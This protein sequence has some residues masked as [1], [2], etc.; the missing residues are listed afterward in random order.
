[1]DRSTRPPPART[2]CPPAA[3]GA[4]Y[5]EAILAA[6]C[7]LPRGVLMTDHKGLKVDVAKELEGRHAVLAFGTF[8]SSDA[9]LVETLA[10]WA[11][12]RQ[13][14]RVAAAAAAAPVHM[15]MARFMVA[16]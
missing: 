13:R 11:R 16:N 7:R 6:P 15:Y 10:R 8:H 14:E 12:E 5:S 2:P 1:M 4:P 9:P 3:A